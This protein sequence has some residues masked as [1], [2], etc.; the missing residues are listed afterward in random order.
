MDVSNFKEIL[1]KLSVLKNYSWL[2]LPVVIILVSMLLFIPTELISSNLKKQIEKK[3]VS[4]GK[5]VQNLSKNT[6]VRDQWQVEQEYQDAYKADAD[7]TAFLIL[8]SCQRPLLNYEMFPEPT[9]KSTLI[10][11][12]FGEQFR[13][14]IKEMLA[15]VKATGC[16][17]DAELQSSLQRSRVSGARRSRSMNWGPGSLS[18]MSEV[19]STII[20]VLCNDKAKFASVY[21][22]PADLSGHEFWKEYEYAGMDESIE[23]CWYWQLGYWIIEDVIDTV[24]AMNAGSKNVFTSPVKRIFDVSFS[25]NSQSLGRR[26]ATGERPHYV[27]TFDEELSDPPTQRS[28]NGEIDI[29]HFNVSVVAS[30]RAILPFMKELCS[31][32]T[33]RFRGFSGKEPE[34]EFKHNQI[35]IL[36]TSIRSI[37]PQDKDHNLYRYGEDAVV[38]LELICEYLLHRKSYEQIKPKTATKLLDDFTG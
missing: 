22:N 34:Q 26:S 32:K 30:S 16:P 28:S 5:Q 25:R 29:I 27:I 6:V 38:E 24:R 21:V 12:T 3:S 33:H 15:R 14:G 19:D 1:Q 2:V 31:A 17:T 9:D 11:E 37:D 20:E 7:K 36:E 18:G 13:K 8:Q 35:T 4:V 10:F 23:D